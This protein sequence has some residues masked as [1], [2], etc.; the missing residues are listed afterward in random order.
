MDGILF[1]H[2]L[3]LGAVL[4]A[5]EILAPGVYFLWLGIAALLVGGVSW[6]WP[7]LHWQYQV[8]LFAVFCVT[9]V[10]LS[11]RWMRPR[12]EGTDQP[13]LNRRGEQYVGRLL[14]LDR[15]IVDGVGRVHVEDTMWR[16]TGPDLPAGA[17]VRVVGVDG[18]TLR[19]DAA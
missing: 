4:V 6:F 13:H 9:D 1:W 18:A 15:P 10:A 8:L 2:W 12:P 3:S 19:V 11:R 16:V 14:T 5:V 7:D 17:R